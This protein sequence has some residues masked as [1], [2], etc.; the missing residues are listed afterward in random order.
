[1]IPTFERCRNHRV[2][3]AFSLRNPVPGAFGSQRKLEI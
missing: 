1:M 3:A 2:V